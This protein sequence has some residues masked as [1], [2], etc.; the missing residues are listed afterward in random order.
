MDEPM[1][2]QSAQVYVV[3][4]QHLQNA[5]L[6]EFLDKES[7]PAVAVKTVGQVEEE[8]LGRIEQNLFLVDFHSVDVNDVIAQLLDT[9]KRLDSDILIGVFNVDNEEAHGQWRFSARLPPGPS[10]QRH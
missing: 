9:D 5:L 10:H 3:G 8:Q 4:S 2:T 6:T 1:E 7:I